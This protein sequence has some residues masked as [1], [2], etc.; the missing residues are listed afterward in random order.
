MEPLK[1]IPDNISVFIDANIFVYHFCSTQDNLSNHCSDFLFKVEQDHIQAMTSTFVVAEVLHRAMI[2]EAIEKTGLPPQGAM[3]KLK[4]DPKLIKS[5][6]HY[7]EIPNIVTD[8]G[9]QIVTI[10]LPTLL[11]SA[12]WRTKYGIMVNDSII[13]AAMS[14]YKISNLVTNDSD[15]KNIPEITVWKPGME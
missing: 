15:F 14:H 9:I 5:L 2:F 6:N 1:N 8:I 3:K 11:A 13:L 12:E 7:Q 4:K 10:S